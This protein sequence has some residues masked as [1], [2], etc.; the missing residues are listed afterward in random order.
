MHKGLLFQIIL[1]GTLYIF[2]K[3][4]YGSW[5]M[6]ASQQ[7]SAYK[8]HLCIWDILE[9]V[10]ENILYKYPFLYLC[11]LRGKYWTSENTFWWAAFHSHVKPGAY[12]QG[13]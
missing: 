9:K 1:V 11:I 8:L 4:N 13:Y 5:L 3:V 12:D 10:K 2:I 7:K 6:T